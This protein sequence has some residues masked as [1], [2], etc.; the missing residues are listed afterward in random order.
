LE[1]INYVAAEGYTFFAVRTSEVLA[2]IEVYTAVLEMIQFFWGVT[3]CCWVSG[4]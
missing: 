1:H 2:R 4:F 3:L